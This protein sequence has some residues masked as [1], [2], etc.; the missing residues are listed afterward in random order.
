[1]SLKECRIRIVDILKDV[2]GVEKNNVYDYDR[3]APTWDKFLEFFKTSDNKLQGWMVTRRRSPKFILAQGGHDTKTHLFIIKGI[4]G[5]ADSDGTEKIFQDL[6]EDIVNKFDDY[7]TLNGIAFTSSP[8]IGAPRLISGIQ[9]EIVEKRKFGTVL[10]HY[11]ELF[12][13]VQEFDY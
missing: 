3:W 13:Y 4:M 7:D 6:I 2:Y 5:L 11:C 9:V 10:C 1:M 12:L 8:V